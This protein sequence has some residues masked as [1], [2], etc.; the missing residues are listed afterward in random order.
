MRTIFIILILILLVGCDSKKTDIKKSK[1]IM[2]IEN[3]LEELKKQNAFNG[4]LLIAKN[5]TIIFQKAYGYANIDFKIPNTLNT[6]FSIASMGKMFTGISVMQLVEKGLLSTNDKV[7]KFLPDYPNKLVRDSITIHQLLTHTSGLPDF[8]TPEYYASAKDQYRTINDLSHLYQTKELKYAPGTKFA[9][10]N[11]DYMVLGLIIENVTGQTYDD[12]I[13]KNIFKIAGMVNTRNYM[14]D[15]IVDNLAVGYSRSTL[16]PGELMKN[17]YLGA[18]TGG[19]AGGGYS[20]L[21]DIFN[22]SKALQNHKFLNKKNTEILTKGKVDNNTYAYGFVDINANQHRIIGHNGGHFGV[23]CE[24]RIFEDLNYTVVLLTNRDAEDGFLDMR[25]YIQK[26]LSGSTSSIE[27][28]YHTKQLIESILDNNNPRT[29]KNIS[30]KLDIREEMLNVEGYYQL[31]LKKYEL[32]IK[33]FKLTAEI[34]PNSANAHDSLGEAYMK[35]GDTINAII[36]YKK[37]IELDA[38]NNNATDM[39]KKMEMN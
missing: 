28:Y 34:F 6:K 32:A 27:S 31:S 10:C 19:P 30:S 33:L 1:E 26:A 15:R 38:S 4:A 2:Q 35:S 25:Y 5:D 20:T 37:S 39:I 13:E 7:G 3:H 17:L 16:Y 8:M 24:L 12:Y 21:S 23:A 22:F 29:S 11:S 14:K 36:N 9:Y 18:I